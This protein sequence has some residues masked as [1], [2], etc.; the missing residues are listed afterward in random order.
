MKHSFEHAFSIIAS[1]CILALLALIL[2]FIS[3]CGS[4]SIEKFADGSYKA[5]SRSL[6][7]DIK[8]VHIKKTDDG[9]VEASMGSSTSDGDSALFLVCTLSPDLSVCDQ[10][11]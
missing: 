2:S 10:G 8:D 9:D 4:V 1:L 3:G 11:P 5:E 6:F 7:K